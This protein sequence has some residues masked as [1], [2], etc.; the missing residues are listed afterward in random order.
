MG[1][2]AFVGFFGI[3]I[4]LDPNDEAT[5]DAVGSDTDPRCINAIRVGLQTHSGNMT[6]GE[7]YFLYIGH[8]LGWLGLEH[9]GHVQLSIDRLTEIQSAVIKKLKVAG[10]LE[11]P[12]LHLQ[13]EAQY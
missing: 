8:R 5:L 7:D 10:F 4:T 13:F 12:A 6:D 11:T 1:A 3:K 2:D 9:E